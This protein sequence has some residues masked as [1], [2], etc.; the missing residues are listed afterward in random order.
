MYERVFN[1]LV[2]L[3]GKPQDY[4]KHGKITIILGD[5]S[6]YSSDRAARYIDYHWGKGVS[7]TNLDYSFDP[8][9]GQGI[10]YVSSPM[11]RFYA[12]KRHDM[13]DVN[14]MLWKIHQQGG[15]N[16]KEFE[17]QFQSGS[18]A[19]T[20]LEARV[21]RSYGVSVRERELFAPQTRQSP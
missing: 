4:E 13:G 10:V 3:Y 6:R 1:G 9:S 18:L 14:F 21:E 7:E 2:A 5:G 19:A 16:R 15:M 12:D 20:L 11:A 17:S 8:R